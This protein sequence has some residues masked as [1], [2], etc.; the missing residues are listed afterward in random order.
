MNG[1]VSPGFTVRRWVMSG[2]SRASTAARFSSSIEPLNL[3]RTTARIGRPSGLNS[4]Y[5]IPTSIARPLKTRFP[6]TSL[7][8]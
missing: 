6:Q 1:R 4:L 5:V 3:T 2:D 8:W 7:R